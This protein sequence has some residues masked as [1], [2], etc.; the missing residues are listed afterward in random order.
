MKVISSLGKIMIALGVIAFIVGAVFLGLGFSKQHYL[1]TT[2]KQ[3]N[4]TLG[5]LGITGAKANELVDS[6]STAQIAGDTVRKH[7]HEIAPNYEAALGG[8]RFDPTNPQDLVYAQ[9]INLENYLYLA[10]SSFGLVYVVLGSGAFMIL[11]GIG[12]GLT[13]V[14]LVKLS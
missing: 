2:M 7:R 4:I 1:V 6:M 9:A 5:N 11:S 14:S 12:M 3:E 10:V 13:G 8:N